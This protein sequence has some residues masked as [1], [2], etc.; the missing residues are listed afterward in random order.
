MITPQELALSTPTPA[1]WEFTD[2]LRAKQP[3]RFLGRAR[4]GAHRHLGVD[5]L[6]ADA[7]FADSRAKRYDCGQEAQWHDAGREVGACRL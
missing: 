6:D 5:H 1:D 7:R 2:S 4:V 3:S